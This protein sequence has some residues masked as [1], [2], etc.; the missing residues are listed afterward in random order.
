MTT[1]MSS[2]IYKVLWLLKVCNYKLSIL[3]ALYL[4]SK[5]YD[6]AGNNYR[7]SDPH[8]RISHSY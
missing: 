7:N 3:L 2:Y 5:W 1:Q 8:C 6:A 4:Q